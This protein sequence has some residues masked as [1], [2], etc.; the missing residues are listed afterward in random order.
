QGALGIF[1]GNAGGTSDSPEGADPVCVARKA[2][3]KQLIAAIA[4]VTLLNT[5]SSGCG[6]TDPATGGFVLIGTLIAEAQAAT[7]AEPNILD[8]SP[9]AKPLWIAEMNSLTAQLTAFNA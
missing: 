9:G 1:W 7:Q 8:C 4:N 5:D 3:A 2:L 6:V